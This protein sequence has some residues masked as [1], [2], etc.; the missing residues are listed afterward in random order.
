MLVSS[1]NDYQVVPTQARDVADVSG[2]GDTVIAM[3]SLCLAIKMN[4]GSMAVLANLAAGLVCEK[5]GVVPIEKEWLM[6]FNDL[7]I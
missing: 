4:I 7:V 2:A 3:A 6:K 5:V 1:G